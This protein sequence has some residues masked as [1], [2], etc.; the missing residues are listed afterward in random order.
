M[1]SWGIDTKYTDRWTRYHDKPCVD[2]EPSSNNGWIYTAYAHLLG[3]PVDI[4]KLS[5]CFKACIVSTDRMVINRTPHKQLPPMSRDE[6]LG[7]VVL[8]LLSAKTL[9]KNHWQFCN[10]DGFRAIPLWRVNWI[11]AIYVLL[12]MGL[13]R[14]IVTLFYRTR[15]APDT[16]ADLAHRNS[17][18]A[19]DDLWN[20]GF[21]L[22]PQDTWYVL[23]SVNKTPAI[24]HTIYFYLSA[25]LTVWGKDASGTLILWMKL[26]DLGMEDSKLFKSINLKKAVGEYFTNTD[27]PIRKVVINGWM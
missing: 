14:L 10:L 8:G 6:I 26:K 17:L 21:R 7:L 13:A 23:K 16:I 9:E 18:W 27:H 25:W 24:L 1:V 2:G 19:E 20:V 15:K 11:K 5:I 12:K 22:P 3:L 4:R